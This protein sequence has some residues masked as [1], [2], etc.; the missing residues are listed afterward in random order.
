MAKQPITHFCV[1]RYAKVFPPNIHTHSDSVV[2]SLPFEEAAKLNLALD[3][4]L[5]IAMREGR[6]TGELFIPK[7]YIE[8][9][10]TISN[11]LVVVYYSDK[12][13]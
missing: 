7:G 9:G 5:K 11:K 13:K 2:F 3:E 1:S 4:S 10:F 8:L 6:K 12:N